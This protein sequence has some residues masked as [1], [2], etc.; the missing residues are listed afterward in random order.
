[1]AGLSSTA[2]AGPADAT[3]RTGHCSGMSAPGNERVDNQAPVLTNDTAKVVSGDLIAIKV[4]A[5][6]SDPES[7]KLY[8]VNG[9]TPAK[10]ETC[11]SGT[12]VLEYWASPSRANY[13]QK[14]T[15]GVTDGDE[16]RTATVTVSVEGLK[17]MRAQLKKR[18]LLRKGG[19][20]V[21][22]RAVVAFTNPNQR[23]LSLWAGNPNA[24][25]PSIRRP[26]KPGQSTTF[27]TKLRRVAFVIVRRDS[28]GELTA[29]NFGSLNTRNG[30]QRNIVVSDFEDESSGS[31]RTSAFKATPGL[32]SPR[33][34]W[35]H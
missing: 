1:M 15:Y 22:R 12:G 29:V 26:I 35:L 30:R 10:G 31:G 5:N 33:T 24:N 21:K 7:D 8:V 17:P 32:A 27:R 14:I 20:K 34:N 6:D 19:H 18:L 16:Y 3:F 28:T 13:T 4:L 2:L 9:S 25:R 11:I 23:T